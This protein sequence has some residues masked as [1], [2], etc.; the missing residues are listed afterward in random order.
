MEYYFGYSYA[1]NDLLCEDFTSRQN[2]W[3]QSRYALEFFQV[4]NV[5][6]W[7]MSNDEN[8]VNSSTDWLLSS[9]D[10]KIHV[11]YRRSITSNTS[12]NMSGLSGSYSVK[13]YNPRTGGTL[14]NGSI[15]SIVGGNNASYGK[16]PNTSDN[17]DWV[18][19]IKQ[20]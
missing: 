10:G 1:E 14:E 7:R 17:M 18:I 13:W 19:L 5:P 2:M 16:P 12:I 20:V 6:F 8:R 4:N 9:S 15:L 3:T 11:V